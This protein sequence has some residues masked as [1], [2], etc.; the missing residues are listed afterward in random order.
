MF[1]VSEP[2][3]PITNISGQTAGSPRVSVD[4]DLPHMRLQLQTGSAFPSCLL[5]DIEVEFQLYGFKIVFRD[6]GAMGTG[7]WR[8][9]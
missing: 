2:T 8:Q 6:P 4:L 5:T 3:Q 1:S 9:N 7:R